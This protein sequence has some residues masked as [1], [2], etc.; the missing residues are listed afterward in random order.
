MV[1][2]DT[3]SPLIESLRLEAYGGLF[4]MPHIRGYH[5]HRYMLYTD[6][7]TNILYALPK[8]PVLDHIRP[9]IFGDYE[10][11]KA[12]IE[13]SISLP[14]LWNNYYTWFENDNN[15]Y[16]S[17]DGLPYEEMIYVEPKT[18]MPMKIIKHDIDYEYQDLHVN[19]GYAKNVRESIFQSIKNTNSF[20]ITYINCLL[21]GSECDISKPI[22]PI[23]L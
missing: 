4:H 18:A 3:P 7:D 12:A 22:P 14:G 6:L 8:F 20:Y 23:P 16:Y 15:R 10:M 21:I 17:D 1:F 19:G 9:T 5:H 13:I 2:F 11:E